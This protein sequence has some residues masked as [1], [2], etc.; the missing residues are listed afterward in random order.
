MKRLLLPMLLVGLVLLLLIPASIAQ[1]DSPVVLTLFTTESDP[2]QLEALNDIIDAYHEMNPNVFVDV[3]VGTPATRGDRTRVL[4]TSGADAGIFE[5]EPAFAK[6]WSAAGFLLPLDDVVDSIGG[7]DA[8]VPGSLFVNDGAVY[9]LPY[10]TSVYG[11][12]YRIDLL[13]EAGLEVPTNYDELIAVAE[14]LT[15]SDEGVYGL[16]IPGSTNASVNFFSTML[17]QNCVDYYTPDGELTF[18][19]PEALQAVERWTALAAY[20]PPGFESWSWGDQITAFITGR[21]AMSVYAGRLGARMPDQAPQLEA[22]SDIAQLPWSYTDGS[23]YVT[24]GNW[25]RYAISANS[26][27]PE[28]A[29][30]FLAFFLSGDQL[31][32]YNATVPGHMVP[33]LDDVG[34]L[35]EGMDSEYMQNHSDWLDFFNA[36][37]QFINHPANNMGSVSGCEFTPQF[38]GPPWGGAI[39]SSGGVIDT[40]LQEI[41]LDVKSAEEAWNDAVAEMISIQEEWEAAQ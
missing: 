4:V 15:N 39:F 30:D 36:N 7:M 32:A 35:I 14:A 29:K 37:A 12:W 41:Y 24:Y 2:P 38:G 13:E 27:N 9:G 28:V 26:A 20:A 6:E 31:A 11:L 17:W 8:Y 1:D 16:S 25:S 21:A 18:D 19:S 3:V 22:V 5:L 40:M 34:N 33:P 10:A 23:P